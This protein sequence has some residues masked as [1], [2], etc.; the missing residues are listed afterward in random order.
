[1]ES[2][3]ADPQALGLL[4]KTFVVWVSSLIGD[5]ATFPTTVRHISNS[6]LMKQSVII[7]IEGEA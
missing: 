6:G 1:M 4:S 5:G 3:P 7:S 2:F